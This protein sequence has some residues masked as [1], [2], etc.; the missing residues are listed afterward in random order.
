MMT[1][2]IVLLVH[3]NRITNRLFSAIFQSADGQYLPGPKKP[4]SG[5]AQSGH[6]I[7]NIV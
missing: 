4:V 2:W 5:V 1:L 7:A 3:E 6:N